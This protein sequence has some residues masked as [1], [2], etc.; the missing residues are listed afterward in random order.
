M[1]RLGLRGGDAM[2]HR[3]SERFRF[4][5]VD[6]SEPHSLSAVLRWAVLDRVRGRRRSSPSS[7]AVPADLALL[8]SPPAPGEGAR[9]TWIGHASWLVQLEGVSLL[10]DPVFA[11][12]LGPVRRNVP[13]ALE[14]ASL[15]FIDAQLV[16]HNH[17]D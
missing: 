14:P 3:S 17:R 5:N 4:V 2:S 6:G 7:A 13:P 1:T 10:I 12:S 15:P 9:L 16:T 11:R 8:R